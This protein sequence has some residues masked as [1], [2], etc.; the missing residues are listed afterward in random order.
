MIHNHEEYL[1]KLEAFDLLSVTSNKLTDEEA[2]QLKDLNYQ[3]EEWENKNTCTK[4]ND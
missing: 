3:I 2:N 4:F 1:R